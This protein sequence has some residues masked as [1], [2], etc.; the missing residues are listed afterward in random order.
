[1]R[2]RWYAPGSVH[3]IVFDFLRL[4][5]QHPDMLVNFVQQ[6]AEKHPNES[7]DPNILRA[8]LITKLQLTTYFGEASGGVGFAVGNELA[9]IYDALVYW[10]VFTEFPFS[11]RGLIYDFR[12]NFMNVAYYEYRKVLENIV[13]GPGVLQ[14]RYYPATAAIIVEKE[15]K[16]L[17]GS[18]SIVSHNGQT[19]V[20]T[21][22]HVLDP[23]AG[24]KF[25]HF[26]LADNLHEAPVSKII[27]SES[28]D[29]A[30]FSISLPES[31]PK[32]FL[33]NESF[34][35]QEVILFGFPKIPRT[36]RP[37]L[38]AHSGEIN[39]TIETWDGERLYLISNYASPGSSGGPLIDYRGLLVGVVSDRLEAEYDE[40][41]SLFQ[42]S[43]AVTLDR[44]QTFIEGRVLPSLV[45]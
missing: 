40:E 16:E 30:A 43:A 25:K 27:K 31:H 26:F 3:Q 42:H 41:P 37:H 21:N 19:F 7:V 9:R 32:F 20:L 28:D 44:L 29:L 22:K 45:R 34:V 8:G 1:M 13:K 5:C 12:I 11:Q 39:A 38:T 36:K 35:L 4:H 14:W 6:C 23:D 18:G 15:D 10:D 17:I 24:I 33:G 2:T